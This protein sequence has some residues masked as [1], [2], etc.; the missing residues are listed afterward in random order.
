M[1]LELSLRGH[2]KKLL[3][4]APDPFY[5][6]R[7]NVVSTARLGICQEEEAWQRAMEG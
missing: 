1:H 3:S 7:C 2:I 4:N 6:S 5:F